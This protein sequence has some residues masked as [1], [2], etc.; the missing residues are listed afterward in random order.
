MTAIDREAALKDFLAAEAALVAFDT[1][2]LV[3]EDSSLNREVE[4]QLR[5]IVQY[6]ARA[7]KQLYS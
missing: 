4:F 1:S 2:R 5:W 7:A 3:N 6:L